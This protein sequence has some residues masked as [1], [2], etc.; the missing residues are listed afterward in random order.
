MMSRIGSFK[1]ENFYNQHY[2]QALKFKMSGAGQNIAPHQITTAKIHGLEELFSKAEPT[3]NL[4]PGL[5]SGSGGSAPKGLDLRING[6]ETDIANLKK[7]VSAGTGAKKGPEVSS[8]RDLK[9][10]DVSK[11]LIGSTLVWD[12]VK[13]VPSVSITD[14]ESTVKRLVLDIE[15]LKAQAIAASKKAAA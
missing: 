8:V 2:K 10:V 11:V 7:D 12:G 14:L 13:W 9:D 3:R 5:L 1:K 6:L 4:L 15:F